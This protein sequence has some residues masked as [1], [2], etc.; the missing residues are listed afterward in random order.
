MDGIENSE[1]VEVSWI[2]GQNDP[3]ESF[4]KR[5]SSSPHFD[6]NENEGFVDNLLNKK[7]A[8]FEECQ[9]DTYYND[10]LNEMT[11]GRRLARYLSTKY[12]WY[13]PSNE[14]GPKLDAAW[15]YFEHFALPR[16]HLEG[17]AQYES[18]SSRWDSF[19]ERRNKKDLLVKADYGE[20]SV[21]TQMY[22]PLNT[23]EK[24]LSD[25]G[26]GIGLYFWTLR[27][28][29]VIFFLAGL[30]SIPNMLYFQSDEYDNSTERD[31][32]GFGIQLSAACTDAEWV[33]CPSCDGKRDISFVAKGTTS[34]ANLVFVLHNKCHV[35]FEQGILAFATLVC[36]F[37]SILVVHA[38]SEKREI[39]LDESVQTTSDYSITIC[40]PPA[41]SFDVDEWKS[42][43]EQLVPDDPEVAAITISIDNKKLIR[44]LLKRRLIIH[45]LEAFLKP[46]HQ[47]DHNNLKEEAVL[48]SCKSVPRWKKVLFYAKDVK[49]YLKQIR[50]LEQQ[51]K[52]LAE[53]GTKVNRVFITFQTEKSQREVLD[54]L[55]FPGYKNIFN[56]NNS[57]KFIP[58]NNLKLF[59]GKHVLHVTE[60]AEPSSIRWL[61]AAD[62]GG[63]KVIE[64]IASYMLVF[65]LIFA[66]AVLVFLASRH[67]ASRAALV[68]AIINQVTPRLS[69]FITTSIESHEEEGFRQAS[70]YVKTTI[71]KWVNT[72]VVT[73]VITP[74]VDTVGSNSDQIISKVFWIFMFELLT[75]PT[76]LAIDIWGHVQRHI[77][78]P[79]ES[80]QER[81]NL[82]FQGAE[83]SLAARYT[84]MMKIIF[85]TVFYSTVYPA[86][87]FFASASMIINYF[88]DKFCLC[89]M[90][91]HTMSIGNAIAKLNRNTFFTIIFV[92]YALMLSRDY[93]GFPF[94][95][96]CDTSDPIADQNK[97][98][99]G[100]HVFVDNK[101]QLQ[102]VSVEETAS[103]FQYCHQNMFRL[104]FPFVPSQQE[105]HKRWMI[106]SQ[107][108]ASYL[109]GWT[110]VVICVI[111]ASLFLKYC[112]VLLWESLFK[113][114]Y[115]PCGKPSKQ[116]F[117]EIREHNGYVPF[118]QHASFMYPLLFCDISN[119]SEGFVDWNDP[120]TPYPYDKHNLIY[121]VPGLVERNAFSYITTWEPSPVLVH[122][123]SRRPKLSKKQ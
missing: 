77:L 84:E 53:D 22:H 38:I 15:A 29:S 24:E 121:D 43:L 73:A 39:K 117:Y 9:A 79:K 76:L 23:P 35:G 26:L 61:D 80:T 27:I 90:Y 49:Y 75:N 33:P 12:A 28:F 1:G 111:A 44:T 45:N 11:W 106:E 110:S 52:E 13:S 116:L 57:K 19:N 81:M 7:A 99:I 55:Y 56:E 20:S 14:G 42:F 89:R 115:K 105:E 85:L 82:Y 10:D 112:F 102:T 86:G 68:I 30:L 64:F 50:E 92:I 74:F 18:G 36:V 78:A 47:M 17:T 70:I 95:N 16:H 63:R 93:A 32:L 59:R 91:G 113:K 103:E 119:I 94:D 118:I 72:A 69:R 96:V 46:G 107:E 51:A 6:E 37:V 5:A 25:F 4:P 21:K 114:T 100:N 60:A 34:D 66:G 104:G 3:L 122:S 48:Q 120:S 8:T 2:K 58:E 97:D 40:N 123:V 31:S 98:Y 88:V 41:D 83:F 67:S 62:T 54:A 65:G 109:L 108:K 101:D 87:F 71:F